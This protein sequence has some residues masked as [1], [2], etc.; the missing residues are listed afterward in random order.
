MRIGELARHAGLTIRTLHHY[1]AIGLLRPSARSPAGYRLYG[2]DDIARLHAIQALRQLGLALDDIRR[3]LAEGGASLP[4][5]VEQ[6]IHALDRQIEQ[7]TELRSRLSLLRAKFSAGDAPE[8][9]D[10]LASL[11]LMNTCN[12]YFSS[13]ELRIIFSNWARIAGDWP[14]LMQDVRRA[15]EQGTPPES[16]AVQPLAYRWMQLMGVWMEGN[17]DLIR[18]WGDMYKREP[19]ALHGSGPDLA[20]IEYVERAV[21]VRIAALCKYLS[22]EQLMGLAALPPQPWHDLSDAVHQ[23]IRRGVPPDS[24]AARALVRHWLA[25]M[26]RVAGGD[27]AVRDKLLTAYRRE[28]LLAAAAV[29]DASV[30]NYL[31]QARRT[32]DPVAA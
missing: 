25:L 4:V 30:R 17:F 1:D 3:L 10:W 14:P 19:A 16:L 7:A 6:Q 24:D 18:R 28:P 8:A 2:P 27:T 20:M 12:K 15:M 32:L 13:A 21:G 31:E 29:I 26:D 23:L 22:L 5:I 11:Q 9:S